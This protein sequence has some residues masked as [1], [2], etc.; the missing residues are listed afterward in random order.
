[1]LHARRRVFVR[2]SDWEYL[3]IIAL[4]TNVSILR[5][6]KGDQEPAA[7]STV[8]QPPE[9]LGLYDG[10]AWNIEQLA[11]WI[12]QHCVVCWQPLVGRQRTYCS[13]KHKQKAYRER[14]S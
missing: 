1:M 3:V 11:T 7:V 8:W 14:R 5:W 4:R 12:S 10:Q 13:D 9:Q 2:V 6:C